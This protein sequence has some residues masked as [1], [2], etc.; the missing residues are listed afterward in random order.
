MGR[1]GSVHR[2]LKR[3]VKRLTHLRAICRTAQAL[4]VCDAV[5]RDR[6]AVPNIE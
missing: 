2:G 3:V 6:C 5:V 4:Q 1:N